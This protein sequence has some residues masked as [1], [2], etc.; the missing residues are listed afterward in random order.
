[1]SSASS[2]AQKRTKFEQV[3]TVIRDELIAH[4]AAAGMPKEATEWFKE[5]RILLLARRRGD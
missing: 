5:V 2:K 3:F 1:M 4:H